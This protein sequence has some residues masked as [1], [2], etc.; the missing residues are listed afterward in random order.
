MLNYRTLLSCVLMLCLISPFASAKG[1]LDDWNNV[2]ILDSGETI[3]VKTKLGE[4]YEGRFDHATADRLYVIVHVPH[5]MQRIIELHKD[6]VKEVRKKL[7][8]VTSLVI[9]TGAGL[10]AGLALG[11]IVDAKDKYGEDPGLGKAV[12]GFLGAS[13]GAAIG[14]RASFNGRRVYEAP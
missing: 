10:G 6:E 4:K 5:V 11:A 14:A 8:R 1:N 9:C 7:A 13:F 3:A 12:L 2:R